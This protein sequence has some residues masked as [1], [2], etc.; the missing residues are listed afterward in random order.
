[1]VLSR[2]SFGAC[3]ICAITGFLA[4][5]AH[6]EDKPA[7]AATPGVKRTV[8]QK[9]ELP[10]SKYVSVLAVVEI[11]GGIAV[12]RH[13]HP[14]V[15]STYVLD[16]DVELMVQ[17]QAARTMKAGDGFQVAPETP[18]SARTGAKGVKLAITYTV[19]KN[20]PISSPAPE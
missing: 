13:T 5:E 16:G 6:A 18:H 20:K 19:D 8:V 9:T 2:R 4:S 7:A 14:G 12:P 1:M 3:A 11:D 10:D 17:G 15:E